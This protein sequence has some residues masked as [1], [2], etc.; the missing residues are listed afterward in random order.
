MEENTMATTK[1]VTHNISHLHEPLKK[2]RILHYHTSVASNILAFMVRKGITSSENYNKIWGNYIE[3]YVQCEE[4]KKLFTEKY[5]V[6]EFG[7]IKGCWEID[8]EK[9]EIHIYEKI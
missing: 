7:C 9:E 8:F 2:L 1:K 6:P 4:S 5:L 3:L